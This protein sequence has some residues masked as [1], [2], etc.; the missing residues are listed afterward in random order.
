MVIN[1]NLSCQGC[2]TISMS[3]SVCR[4]A[5][6][7]MP[8][9]KRL[10]WRKTKI[11]IPQIEHLKNSIGQLVDIFILSCKNNTKGKTDYDELAANLK[12]RFTE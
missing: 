3:D 11:E 7:Q 2:K 4:A 9:L 1:N 6:R 12:I 10:M 5:S 8:R